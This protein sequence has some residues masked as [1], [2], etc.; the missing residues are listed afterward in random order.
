MLSYLK[1][2]PMGLH[3]MLALGWAFVGVWVQELLLDLLLENL[4]ACWVVL[5]PGRSPLFCHLPRRDCS[6]LWISVIFHDESQ[7]NN[8]CYLYY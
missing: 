5:L 7:M 4:G 6:F 2:S 3:E 1:T 8:C